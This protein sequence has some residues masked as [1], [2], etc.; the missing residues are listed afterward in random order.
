[1]ASD[2]YLRGMYVSQLGSNVGGPCLGDGIVNAYI[3]LAAPKIR[4]FLRQAI[5]LPI[6]QG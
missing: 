3:N 2:V 6:G 4:M 1:M 5:N